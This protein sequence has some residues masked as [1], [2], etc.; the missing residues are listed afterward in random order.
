MDGLHAV[1]VTYAYRII[2]ILCVD[3]DAITLLDID[4]HDMAYR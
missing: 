3:D 2:L 1:S 4:S